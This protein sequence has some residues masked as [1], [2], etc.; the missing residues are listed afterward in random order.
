MALLA[1]W[2]LN[3]LNLTPSLLALVTTVLAGYFMIRAAAPLGL[4]DL[5]G[6]RKI[7][8]LATPRTGG[9]AMA[10]GGSLAWG[11]SL[12]LAWSPRPAIPWQTWVA[13]AGFLAMGALDD[14]YTFLPRQKFLILLSL[15]AL[16]AW[17]WAASVQVNGL[18]WIPSAWAGSPL[19]LTAASAVLTFW[20]M[21]VPNSVNIED[22]INGYMG[23]YAFIV[24]AGLLAMGVDTRI[25]MGALLG[26]LV[27]NWPKAKH[28]MGDA[29]SFGCGFLMAEAILRGGGLIHPTVALAFTAPISMDVAMGLVRRRRLKMSL[30]SADRLTC[31]HHLL[32]RMKGNATLAAL[33]LW[34]NALAFVGLSPWPYLTLL[35]AGLYAGALVILNARF[36][37]TNSPRS[38]GSVLPGGLHYT[39]DGLGSLE[40]GLPQSLLKAE[41]RGPTDLGNTTPSD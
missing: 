18:P 21:A 40:K 36:L 8:T 10:V 17:P 3:M 15:S 23:G 1:D 9:L 6:D 5:P 25:P 32:D 4:I 16:A 30:F 2:N 24:L 34:A 13:G 33:A 22:A 35:Q 27:F 20:F 38:A 37:F 19:L 28:F 14:H 12:A 29:G 41:K 39:P 7:H 11:L 26:F 31:P